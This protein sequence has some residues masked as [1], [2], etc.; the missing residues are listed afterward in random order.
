MITSKA[1]AVANAGR[2]IV[3]A[4]QK[5]GIK[6]D[7]IDVTVTSTVSNN[8]D[9]VT[10]RNYTAEILQRANGSWEMQTIM[11]KDTIGE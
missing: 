3:E 11:D 2:Q 8:D 4:M 7:S 1:N 9:G 6:F 10:V 5:A